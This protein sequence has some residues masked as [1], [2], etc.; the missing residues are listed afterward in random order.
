MDALLYKRIENIKNSVSLWDVLDMFNV[1]NNRD[2]DRHIYCP[3]HY[4]TQPSFK[5]YRA[6]DGVLT[7][8]CFSCQRGGDVIRLYQLL[9]QRE[10]PSFARGSAIVELEKLFNL[11]I[12]QKS[13]DI[14]QE[15][16]NKA[17]S[18]FDLAADT[19]SNKFNSLFVAADLFIA[20]SIFNLRK[21]LELD[22]DKV[23]L[24]W[25]ELDSI[26]D[27]DKEN[28][29]KINDLSLF[30]DSILSRLRQCV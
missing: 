7:F 8:Y 25:K 16:F 5:V 13:V 20:D 18:K 28:K 17:F 3:F 10:D 15:Q 12:P 19:D 27:M 23:L 21:E 9:K 29:E 2:V 26:K 30:C 14:Y 24:L 1:D 4:E 6:E 11:E 22:P